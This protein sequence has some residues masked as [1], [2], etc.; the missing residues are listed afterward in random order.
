MFGKLIRARTYGL[1]KYLNLIDVK[2]LMKA[3]WIFSLQE[4]HSR[5]IE[6]RKWQ[7][8]K[9]K[10]AGSRLKKELFD[11]HSTTIYFCTLNYFFEG[12]AQYS[13]CTECYVSSQQSFTAIRQQSKARTRRYYK[14]K[15]YVSGITYFPRVISSSNKL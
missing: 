1:E 2:I 7:L 12:Y 8:G 10:W 9:Y 13:N 5:H 14:Y 11:R 3:I 4:R 6:D 15:N